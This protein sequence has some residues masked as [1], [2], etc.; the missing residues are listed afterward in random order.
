MKVSVQHKSNTVTY[1]VLGIVFLVLFGTALFAFS[2]AHESRQAEEKAQELQ[3]QLS[4]A[5]MRVPTTD[6]IVRVLGD[7]GGAVCDSPGNALRRATLYGLLTNGAA[8]PGQR[9]VIA[10]NKAVQGQLIIIKVYCPQYIEEFQEV[11]DDLKLD[12]VAAT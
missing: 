1:V 11:I 10:D 12:D 3:S 4:A 8:G 9:P 5:G 7:D 6:Q 2:S